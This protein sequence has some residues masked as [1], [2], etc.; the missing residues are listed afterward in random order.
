LAAL[1][2]DDILNLGGKGEIARALEREKSIKLEAVRVPDPLHG[3]RRDPDNVSLPLRPSHKINPLHKFL[4][5][6]SPPT[7]LQK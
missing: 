6:L 2:A 3:T 4:A 5:A 1:K 7:K